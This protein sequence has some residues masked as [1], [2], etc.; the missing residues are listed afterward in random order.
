ML[1]NACL[2]FGLNKY[3]EEL[4]E[5]ELYQIEDALQ[6]CLL[7]MVWAQ[8]KLGSDIAIHE[9]QAIPHIYQCR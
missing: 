6:L 2:F 5:V 8:I 7:L 4:F 1:T 9:S 3:K